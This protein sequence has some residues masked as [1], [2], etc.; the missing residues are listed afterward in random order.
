MIVVTA[1]RIEELARRAGDAPRKR[2][3]DV[4]PGDP[5]DG[6]QPFL[7]ALDPDAYVRPHR[8][9]G[10]GGREV[11]AAL[12]GRALAAVFDDAGLVT[13]HA[14]LC[15]HGGTRAVEVEAG[16]WHTLL[17]LEPGTVLLVVKEGPYDPASG[18]TPAPWAPAEGA[19]GAG[20][21]QRWLRESPRS[22]G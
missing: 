6:I 19:P 10:S 17:A 21:F 9:G 3:H 14:V 8:H 1:Q 20:A 15:A 16:R 7:L 5:G 18:K 4:F 11:V 12:R 2:A 22:G 13:E